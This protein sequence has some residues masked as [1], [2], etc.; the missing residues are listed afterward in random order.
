MEA[1]K[2]M[3][4][5]ERHANGWVVHY[6]PEELS[7]GQMMHHSLAKIF[8]DGENIEWD[9]DDNPGK[10]FLESM[11]SMQS[12]QEMHK[13][14]SMVYRQHERERMMEDMDHFFMTGIPPAAATVTENESE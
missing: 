1:D 13:P 2:P 8:G 11:K 6:R 9:K 7:S 4:K 12:M 10:K 5:V 14:T 3:L